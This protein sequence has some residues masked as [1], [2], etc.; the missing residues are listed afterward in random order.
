MRGDSMGG[1][2]ELKII[3]DDNGFVQALIL[4]GVQL[5]DITDCILKFD[6]ASNFAHVTLELLANVEMQTQEL[7]DDETKIG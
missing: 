3:K 5:Q 2:S 4:N 1:L 7:T 6:G